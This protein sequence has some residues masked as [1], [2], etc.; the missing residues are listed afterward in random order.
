VEFLC[1]WNWERC[2]VKIDETESLHLPV[3]VLSQM[4]AVHTLSPCFTNI[5][6][7]IILPF[8]SGSF[9]WFLTLS[10]FQQKYYANFSFLMRAICPV[11]RIIPVV[12]ADVWSV[13]S[14][15]LCVCCPTNGTCRRLPI[16]CRLCLFGFLANGLNDA[17]IRETPGEEKWRFLIVG[18]PCVIWPIS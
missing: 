5:Y 18:A 9:A 13:I 6:S 16:R 8:T 10:S 11:Q 4:N 1:E 2:D 7:N 12:A 3:P 17:R 15:G 14:F